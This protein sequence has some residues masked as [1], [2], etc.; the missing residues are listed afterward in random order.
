[1]NVE[2][3]ERIVTATLNVPQ[4]E[5]VVPS[6]GAAYTACGLSGITGWCWMRQAP[7]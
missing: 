7:R 4:S 3:L 2:R 1:M 5:R 6:R